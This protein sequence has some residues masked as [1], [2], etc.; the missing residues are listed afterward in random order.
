[1]HSRS[2]KKRAS[3]AA[4]ATAFSKILDLPDNLRRPSEPF[5]YFYGKVPDHEPVVAHTCTNVCWRS[6]ERSGQLYVGRWESNDL[7]G[8]SGTRGSENSCEAKCDVAGRIEDLVSASGVTRMNAGGRRPK[9]RWQ[10][11]RSPAPHSSMAANERRGADGPGCKPAYCP[12][13]F[14]GREKTR[15]PARTPA[16]RQGRLPHWDTAPIET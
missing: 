4:Y 5:L 12:A 8:L 6:L 15:K 16:C 13:F 10:A 9:A 1:M 11:T 2:D 3:L 7:L 14:V